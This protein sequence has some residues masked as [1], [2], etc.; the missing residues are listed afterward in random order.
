MWTTAGDAVLVACPD[1][2]DRFRFVGVAAL[3]WQRMEK[4]CQIDEL[5]DAVVSVYRV[6][7]DEAEA[8]VLSFVESLVVHR[9]LHE[10]GNGGPPV[11][12][13]GS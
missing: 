8:D 9:L 10:V 3:I 12:P 5:V 11:A 1:I 13:A 4:P 7:P 6:T 2:P